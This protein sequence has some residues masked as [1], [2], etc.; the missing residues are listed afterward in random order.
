MEQLFPLPMSSNR[1]RLGSHSHL[2]HR[3]TYGRGPATMTRSTSRPTTLST[4]TRSQPQVLKSN[5]SATKSQA[6]RRCPP[7]NSSSRPSKRNKG[8]SQ[9]HRTPASPT[10][11]SPHSS[12][13]HS[14][15]QAKH[16]QAIFQPSLTRSVSPT[17]CRR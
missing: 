15:Q 9:S 16:T 11:T 6:T 17:R 3:L 10:R 1:T 5:S 13:T 7:T 14:L 4:T 12:H 8:L 2:K